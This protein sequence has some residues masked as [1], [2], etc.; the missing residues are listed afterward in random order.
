MLSFLTWVTKVFWEHWAKGWGG[1][2]NAEGCGGGRISKDKHYLPHHLS[3]ANLSSEFINSARRAPSNNAKVN[4]WSSFG[5]ADFHKQV[6]NLTHNPQGLSNKQTR[7][8][9]ASQTLSSSHIKSTRLQLL[10]THDLSP[11]WSAAKVSLVL[12]E[13]SPPLCS[14]SL[15]LDHLKGFAS[16]VLS[17]LPQLS[18]PLF[19]CSHWQINMFT[20]PHSPM[21][22]SSPSLPALRDR[23]RLCLCSSH[24]P[25]YSALPDHTQPTA[26]NSVGCWW[27]LYRHFWPQPLCSTLLLYPSL[28]LTYLLGD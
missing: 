6:V 4:F 9:R 5:A 16:V 23:P 20:S 22:V 3:R 2:R 28:D 27:C 25:Y 21:S 17:F 13:T 10:C 15:L 11:L 18:F 24:P 12:W 19:I 1:G 26:L 14:G 7:G 8:F